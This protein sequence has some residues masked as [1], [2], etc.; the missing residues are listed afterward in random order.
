MAGATKL[1]GLAASYAIFVGVDVSDVESP[2]GL[3]VLCHVKGVRGY[4]QGRSRYCG[5]RVGCRA[6]SCPES[7]IADLPRLTAT[8]R[9][10]FAAPLRCARSLLAQRFLRDAA[11][12]SS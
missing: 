4:T 8:L 12:C 10:L 3:G 11:E 6:G 2:L 1:E 5:R 9:V 7:L